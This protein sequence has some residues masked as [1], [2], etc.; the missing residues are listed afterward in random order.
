[1]LL[2]H[3]SVCKEHGYTIILNRSN[4]KDSV[5]RS[6]IYHKTQEY[7]LAI[8]SPVLQL[9]GVEITYESIERNL[10]YKN[11]RNYAEIVVVNRS[12]YPSIIFSLLSAKFPTCICKISEN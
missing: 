6:D 9:V 5:L 4:D 7:F 12:A 11:R 8:F 3:Q 10:G 2:D 1:M